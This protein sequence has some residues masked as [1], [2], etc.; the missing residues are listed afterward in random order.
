MVGVALDAADQ[1]AHGAGHVV[2]TAG[3]VT[4]LV[5]CR[6]LDCG[7]EIAGGEAFA[8]LAQA[9]DAGHYR[10]VGAHRQVADHRQHHQQHGEV[11]V[12]H[13]PGV[14]DALL[15]QLIQVRQQHVVHLRVG[16]AD[17]LG[18]HVEELRG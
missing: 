2:E 5:A 8:A 17:R 9:A 6:Q 3:H 11:A 12:Q 1:R 18:G 7:G 13:L 16:N 15:Q 14:I 4:Q 10:Q